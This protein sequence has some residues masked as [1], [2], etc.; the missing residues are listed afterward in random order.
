VDNGSTDATKEI[1]HSFVSR[2]PLTYAFEP[3]RGKNAALNFGLA[4]AEGDL[5]AFSDDDVF[6]RADWLMEMRHA[7]D[8]HPSVS[9]FGGTV[10]ARWERFPE[11]W[12]FRCV[13]LGPVFGI[14]DP[15]WEEGPL[16]E[17]G[18][19]FGANMGIRADIFEAGYRFNV[20]IGPGR[21]CPM[22]SETELNLRLAKAGCKIWHSKQAI[23]EHFVPESRM[24]RSWILD[25]A[26]KFG[27]EQYRLRGR[28]AHAKDKFY[29]GI[30]WQLIKAI[31]T[32][33]FLLGPAALGVNSMGAFQNAWKF[34]YLLGQA[35]EARLSC[36][37]DI[38]A[39]GLDTKSDCSRGFLNGQ[40]H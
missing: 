21:D 34:H 25:R 1:I 31:A 7:A 30:P 22:G 10:I 13:P 12:I 24:D 28:F 19:A 17:P 38:S 40:T 3:L 18:C 5:I 29:A 35:R 8:S 37:E 20:D 6:P 33:A 32:R 14:T 2:L 39:E 15:S 36:R 26:F 11:D 9:I 27:R 23:V 16:T 4:S